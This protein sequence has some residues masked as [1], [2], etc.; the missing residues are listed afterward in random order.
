MRKR[1]VVLAVGLAG[2]LLGGLLLAFRTWS[3]TGTPLAVWAVPAVFVVGGLTLV[4]RRRDGV[5]WGRYAGS[6]GARA[7]GVPA[8]RGA[9]HAGPDVPVDHGSLDPAEFE[10]AVAALCARDG[11]TAVEVSGGAGDLGADVVATTREGARVVL[12]CK[13]YHP[14]RRVGSQDLQRFGGT[15]FSVHGASFAVVVTTS[16]FTEPAADYAA[17]CG[18]IC[19]DAEG[20][21]AWSAQQAPPPWEA[22]VGAPSER[23]V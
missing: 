10:H 6:R 4:G 12:Q 7:D 16:G 5:R 11:C 3:A 13:R 18:I 19:V 2:I 14:D 15:C 23:G 1:D 9:V 20:L 8:P 22:G 21:A 17:R